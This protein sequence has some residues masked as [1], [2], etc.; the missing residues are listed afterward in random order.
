MTE[1][2]YAEA[3]AFHRVFDDRAPAKPQ[4]LGQAELIDRAGFMLEELTEFATST[5]TSAADVDAVFAA[6]QDKLAS[7]RAK[8]ARKPASATPP[9]VKQADAVGDML[10][11]AYGNFVLMGVEPTAVLDA[12]HAAN[13]HKLFPDGTAHRDPVTNKVLKPAS[14]AVQYQ[15]EPAITRAIV[16]QTTASQD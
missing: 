15:P 14:W 7:A 16:Q 12:I 4:A 13:M 1:Q 10:Y 9:L 3:Q 11:L 5:A 8:L 6:L 2:H